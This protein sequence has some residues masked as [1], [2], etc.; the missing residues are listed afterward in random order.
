VIRCVRRRSWKLAASSYFVLDAKDLSGVCA[1]KAADPRVLEKLQRIWLDPDP[2]HGGLKGLRSYLN[3]LC[4]NC[5]VN[6]LQKTFA[7]K[8]NNVST[9]S[10]D[11]EYG[12]V[13]QSLSEHEYANHTESADDES[14]VVTLLDFLTADGDQP[15]FMRDVQEAFTPD[16]YEIVLDLIAGASLREIAAE[17]GKSKSGVGRE[18]QKITAKLQQW[19]KEAEAAHQV[20]YVHPRNRVFGIR[21]TRP[22]RISEEN[23]NRWNDSL[24]ISQLFVC[25]HL[26]PDDNDQGAPETFMN[27]DLAGAVPTADRYGLCAQCWSLYWLKSSEMLAAE[28]A[29]LRHEIALEDV[30]SGLVNEIGGLALGAT[31]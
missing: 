6:E 25:R 20:R 7:A 24:V 19:V 1:L 26:R 14:G 22:D 17:S 23:A 8:R 12:D 4:H 21:T 2:N 15:F 11:Y 10:L 3:K 5:Y 18:A 9:L 29:R 16:E 30:I 13:A 28:I 27:F 31:K